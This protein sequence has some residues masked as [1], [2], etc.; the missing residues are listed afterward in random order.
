M[1][2]KIYTYLG[3][4]I[5]YFSITTINLFFKNYFGSPL[6]NSAAIVRE[7]LIF[8][9]VGL[10]FW[11][12]IKKEKLPL[13]SIGLYSGGWKKSLLWAALTLVLCGIG[14][15]LSV[16]IAQQLGWPFGQSNAFDQLSLWTITLIVLRAGIA[17]EVFFRGYI[18]ER[19]TSLTS[20]KYL[21]AA[22]SLIPFALFHYTQGYAGILIAF[23]LG[24]ILTVTYLWRRDLKSNIIAHFLTD[25]IPNVLI[26]LFSEG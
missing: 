14:L 2:N 16:F 3:L 19:L 24:G 6:N 13:S 10:L 26:P 18:I 12:I 20:N 9:M 5:S 15:V 21:A 11:I 8:L 7:L 4:L 25:F 17:E 23:V 1:N 22:L